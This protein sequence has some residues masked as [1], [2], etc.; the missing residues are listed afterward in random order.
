MDAMPENASMQEREVKLT[1]PQL[2]SERDANQGSDRAGSK[3]QR[4][5]PRALH[6]LKVIA[7]V[8]LDLLLHPV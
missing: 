8:D 5:D 1:V 7:I 3:G 6:L 4:I 2:T